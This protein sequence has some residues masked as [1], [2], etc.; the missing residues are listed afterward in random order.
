MPA[1]SETQQVEVNCRV[2]GLPFTACRYVLPDK[3]VIIAGVC[4]KCY[5]AKVVAIRED[6]A[7]KEATTERWLQLCPILYQRTDPARLPQTQLPEVLAWQY[8]PEGLLL[9]GPTGTYK[10]RTAY[11]L[12]KRLVLD[13]GRRVEAFDGLAFDH[14]CVRRF[15]DEGDG[16][17]WADGL[18]H[19]D[20]VFFDDIGKGCFT[21]RVE[22]EM[23]GLIE[24]RAANGLP[25][26]ATTNMTGAD[27]AAKVTEDRGAPLIRRLREFCK[28][29]TFA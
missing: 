21:P 10:T 18:A 26:I 17:E 14:E 12:L 27:L 1:D 20:V 28:C 22:A 3:R 9:V 7:K 19:V 8:G 24:R 4:D 13:E 16:E 23:F 6:A 15:R 29:V 25:I 5:G 2:C 11:L